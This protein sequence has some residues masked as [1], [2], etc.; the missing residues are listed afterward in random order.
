[1]ARLDTGRLQPA[2]RGADVASCSSRIIDSRC[3]PGRPH[4]IELDA[5]VAAAR[6]LRRPR[7]VHPGRHQRGRE[8]RPAR[9]AAPCGS[10]PSRWFNEGWTT[11]GVRLTVD[12]EGEGIPIEMRRR[13][14]TKFWTGPAPAA[15]PASACT[16]ST[17]SPAP[18]AARSRS[19]TRPDGGARI[20]DW[21]GLGA[22]RD[23]R[24]ADRV[25]L[26]TTF[27]SH[28]PVRARRSL[29]RSQH[30]IRR[31]CWSSRTSR[32]INEAVADRLRAE[33]FAVEQAYDGPGAVERY[34][35]DRPDLV[36]LDV[37]LP[38]FDGLEVC[39]RIQAQPRRCRC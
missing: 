18:T 4:D 3:R 10:R 15:A 16:S 29:L 20:V 13:V 31:A 30:G 37:M 12:D 36:V 14:F 34:A 23:R 1:M 26:H 17:A 21:P 6:D 8:R 33:G 28:A 5:A 19:S 39:R 24:L 22:G 38:G 25:D 11:D 2:R 32:V 9:R 7:Q 27:T 35:A